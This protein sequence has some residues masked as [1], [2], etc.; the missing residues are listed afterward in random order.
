MT[1]VIVNS[2]SENEIFSSLKVDTFSKGIYFL[3]FK[4]GNSTMNKKI[5]LN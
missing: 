2:N 3:K 4:Q 1:K 5:I